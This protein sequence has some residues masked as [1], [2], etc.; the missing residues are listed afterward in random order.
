[1]TKISKQTELTQKNLQEAFWTIYSKQNIDKV[2]VKDICNLA[3]YNRSTFYQY[4]IDVYDMLHKSESQIL[5][6]IYEFVIHLVEQANNMNT[7]QVIQTIF[8]L[9]VQ[10]SK[11]MSVLFGS[12][13]DIEFNHKVVETLKPLWIKYFFNSANH[14]PAEVDLLM[15]FY[16]SGLL[17]MYQKWYNDN[18]GISFERIIQLS[19]QTLPNTSCFENFDIDFRQ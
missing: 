19:Y 9:F 13:G 7:S 14:T 4:Y 15:E 1:M 6:E 5:D 11:F 12:H 2:T 18:N 17:S 16:I 3:G 8:E 10:N